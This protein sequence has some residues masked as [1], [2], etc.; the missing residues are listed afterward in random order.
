MIDE[1]I[2]EFQKSRTISAIDHAADASLGHSYALAGRTG[3]ARKILQ[4]MLAVK[5]SAPFEIALVYQG[6]GEKQQVLNWLERIDD[7]EGD[8][9]SMVL[10]LDPRLDNLRSEPR[11]QKLLIKHTS[12]V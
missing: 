3:D 10:R 11:F 4:Q 2:S 6:L 1:A 5:N 9:L 8:E 7:A 12:S